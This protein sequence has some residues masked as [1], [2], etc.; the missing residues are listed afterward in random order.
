[1]EDRLN[2][3]AG[4]LH[5]LDNLRALMMW[6]GIVLH[7]AVIHG[8]R[9]ALLPW[10]DERRTALVDFLMAFIHAFRMPVFFILAGY[11]V[12]LLAR[13]RGAGGLAR[14]RLRRL[15]LPFLVFWPPVF[16]ACVVL[17]LLFL[18]RIVRGSWGL[19]RSL[20]ADHPTV[21]QG[22]S[23]MHMWF[24]WLLL[25]FS[26]LAAALLRWFDGPWLQRGA[27]ILRR[28]GSTAW[29]PVVLTLPLVLAGLGY[30]DGLVRPN[31]AFLPPAAEWLHNGMFF[32]FG[33]ALLGHQQPL[34]DL[35][36]RRCK[37][38]ALA[39]VLPFVAAGALVEA[40]APAVAIAFVYNMSSWLWSF[41]LIGL[42]LRVLDRRSAW[43]SYLADSSYW[44]Y[45]VHMPLTIGLGALLFGLALPAVAKMAINISATTLVCLVSYQLFVR[46]TWVSVLLNG[47]RH[48][49]SAGDLQHSAPRS[50]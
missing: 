10:R 30:P 25:W 48:V 9:E 50:A 39:G 20:M 2:A 24:L 33:L 15:G 7:V 41:A 40:H 29:G 21:P 4:R 38:Y 35:Y 43:L 49:R 8:E 17:S 27:A 3:P 47:K 16:A 5:A 13:S 19:D 44:V 12:A 23:T 46:F 6:L 34:F 1:M 22:P 42:A 45:L 11:F 26:L 32:V 31:G 37:A 28:L 18:H 14:H 36:R